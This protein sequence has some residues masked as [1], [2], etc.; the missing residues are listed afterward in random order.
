[1]CRQYLCEIYPSYASP[2]EGGIVSTETFTNG[3]KIQGLTFLA[4]RLPAGVESLLDA[5]ERIYPTA[6]LQSMKMCLISLESLDQK[7]KLQNL[8]E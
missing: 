8:P 7:L 3:R 2:V 1:M 4:L 5:M 6:R